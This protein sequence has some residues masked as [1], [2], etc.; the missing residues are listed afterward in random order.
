MRRRGRWSS[1][2][3]TNSNAPVADE[4]QGDSRLSVFPNV[5]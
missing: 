1:V 3:S 5:G 4:W 2:P